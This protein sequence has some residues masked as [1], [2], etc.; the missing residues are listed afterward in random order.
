APDRMC[1]ECP[2]RLA[3]RVVGLRDRQHARGAPIET[4]NDPRPQWTLD[5]AEGDSQ[6]A[7][8]VHQRAGGPAVA[9]GHRHARGLVDEGE[10]IALGKDADWNR[11]G[12]ELGP[13]ALAEDEDALAGDEPWSAGEDGAPVEPDAAGGGEAADL[14]DRNAQALRDQAVEPRPLH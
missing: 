2:D 9:R 11:L 8:G 12:E 3:M 10:A 1:Y 7:Q 4:M 14:G 13:D 5:G 6:P